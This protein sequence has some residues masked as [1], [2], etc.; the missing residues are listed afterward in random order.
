MGTISPVSRR[1]ASARYEDEAVSTEQ[2]KFN[3]GEGLKNMS[4]LKTMQASNF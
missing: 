1:N 4:P 3:W 2:F